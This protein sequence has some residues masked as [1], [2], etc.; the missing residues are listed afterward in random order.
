MRTNDILLPAGAIASLGSLSAIYRTYRRDIRRA[1]ARLSTGR[2]VINTKRGPIEFA[3]IGEGMPLL[4]VHGA[5]GGFDQALDFVTG[6]NQAAFRC[7]CVSRF[8]YL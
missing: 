4:L 8:G 5:G 6:L 7:I 3:S 1:R 2:S